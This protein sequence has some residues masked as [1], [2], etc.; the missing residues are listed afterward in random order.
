MLFISENRRESGD[1]GDPFKAL[2]RLIR[3]GFF[4]DLFTRIG[5]KFPSATSESIH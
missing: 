3:T 2:S 4:N 1:A 5:L